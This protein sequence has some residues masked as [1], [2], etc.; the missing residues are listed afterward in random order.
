MGNTDAAAWQTGNALAFQM[1]REIAAGSFEDMAYE[2]TYRDGRPQRNVVA[3]YFA[4]LRDLQDT[5]CDMAFAA[6]L[7]DYLA[8]NMHAGEPD[9]AVTSGRF[10]QPIASQVRP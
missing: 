4:K 10:T 6:V 2:D 3:A 9:I 8:M 5:R 1:L 7:T